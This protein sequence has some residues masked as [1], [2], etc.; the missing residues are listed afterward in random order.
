MAQPAQDVGALVAVQDLIASLLAGVG[1]DDQ[2]RV[3]AFAAD[4]LRQLLQPLLAHHV[5]VRGMRAQ[6]VQRDA[7]QTVAAPGVGTTWRRGR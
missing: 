6:A 7:H 2:R 4:V 5:G 1:A 3:L